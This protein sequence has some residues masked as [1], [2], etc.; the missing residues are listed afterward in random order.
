ML[1]DLAAAMKKAITAGGRSKNP[2]KA[3]KESNAKKRQEKVTKSDPG[4]KRAGSAQRYAKASRLGS[5][6]VHS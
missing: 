6:G 4:L 3:Q 2:N 5:D 1:S